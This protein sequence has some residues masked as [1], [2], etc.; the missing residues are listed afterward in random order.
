MRRDKYMRGTLPTF[1]YHSFPILK[2]HSQSEGI[3]SPLH[4]DSIG[5]SDDIPA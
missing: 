1:L 2:L 3:V 5:K 4:Q